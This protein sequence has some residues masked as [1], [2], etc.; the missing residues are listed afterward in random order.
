MVMPDVEDVAS[1]NFKGGVAVLRRAEASPIGDSHVQGAA[2][3]LSRRF[4]DESPLD[5]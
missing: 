4:A 1:G 2:S 3:S 5:R